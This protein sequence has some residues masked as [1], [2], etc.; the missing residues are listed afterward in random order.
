MLIGVLEESRI[1]HPND[2]ESSCWCSF[3]LQSN[4]DMSC[5]GMDSW[6]SSGWLVAG[7]FVSWFNTWKLSK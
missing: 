4:Q 2:D 1:I 7:H 3:L 6:N 5:T